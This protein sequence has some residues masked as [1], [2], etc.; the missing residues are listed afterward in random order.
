MHTDQN[1]LRSLAQGDELAF[2]EIYARYW[3]KMY[4]AA[5]KRLPQHETVKDILQEIFLQ[6]WARKEVLEIANLSAY[7]MT[8]VRNRV[9]SQYE[10]EDR[11]TPIDS[12]L[13]EL[14]HATAG[15]DTDTQILRKE[16]MQSYHALLA[17]VTPSQ[18]TILRLRFEDDLNTEEIAQQLNISRKTVQNQLR[19]A[20]IQI[21]A[22]LLSSL[23][24]VMWKDWL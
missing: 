20:L 12:L 4:A 6:L 10:K 21:R 5:F 23:V 16:L 19:S 1:L 11:Y 2:R 18:Q 7:L 13:M 3:K 15:T 14:S 8:A 17:T 24:V 9:I 22:A